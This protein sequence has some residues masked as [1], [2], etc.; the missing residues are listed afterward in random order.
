MKSLWFMPLAFLAGVD[1]FILFAL[2]LAIFLTAAYLIRARQRS[3]TASDSPLLSAVLADQ[4][5]AL[6]S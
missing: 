3:L 2:Y 4:L 5:T 1:G 6:P